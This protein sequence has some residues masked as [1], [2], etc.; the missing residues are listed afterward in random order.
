[1]VEMSMWIFSLPED[2]RLKLRLM[3]TLLGKSSSAIVKELIE[4]K[5]AKFS[6]ENISDSKIERI[7]EQVAKFSKRIL[8]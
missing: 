1:M 5:W 6:E 3:A 4:E 8:K 7:Q 2:T